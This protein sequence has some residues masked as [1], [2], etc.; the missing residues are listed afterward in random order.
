MEYAVHLYDYT[1][2]EFKASIQESS[3]YEIV[4]QRSDVLF[5]VSGPD[6]AIN[7]LE[8]FEEVYMVST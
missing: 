4:E 7:H 1:A 6:G 2:S 5:I 3:R 8:M